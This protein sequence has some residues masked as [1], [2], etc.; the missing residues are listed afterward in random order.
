MTYFTDTEQTFQ[1]FIWNHKQP[2]IAAVIL[3]KKNKAGGIRIPDIKLYD[4]ATVIKTAWYW[5]KNGHIDQWN[6]IESQEINPKFMAINIRQRRQEH[7]TEQ[8]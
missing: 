7:Q 4:K 8:K 2:Q 6:R 5:H 3:R 1:K